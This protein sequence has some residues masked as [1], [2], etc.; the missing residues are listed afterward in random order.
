MVVHQE[1]ALRLDLLGFLFES[2]LFA[3]DV[4]VIATVLFRSCS[5]RANGADG[6]PQLL[7]FLRQAY[8]LHHSETR[9]LAAIVGKIFHHIHHLFSGLPIPRHLGRHVKPL[10]SHLGRWELQWQSQ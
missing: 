4:V 1:W 7:I 6:L 2:V 8:D 5:V 9:E 10:R 3:L